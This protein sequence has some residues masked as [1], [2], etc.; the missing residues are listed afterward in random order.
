LIGTG[1]F[2]ARSL[3]S[4]SGR[5]QLHSRLYFT[6]Q[7]RTRPPHN[8]CLPFSST[9]TQYFDLRSLVLTQ[10]SWAI[11]GP[12]F[13]ASLAGVSNEGGQPETDGLGMRHIGGHR[14]KA[15]KEILNFARTAGAWT[16]LLGTLPGRRRSIMKC[17]NSAYMFSSRT[18]TLPPKYSVHY[19]C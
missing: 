5:V 1:T 6:F 18:L 8:V 10:T 2:P 11:P 3:L 13:S 16:F 19:S 9:A 12:L 7:L 4:K 14:H 15:A 17:I